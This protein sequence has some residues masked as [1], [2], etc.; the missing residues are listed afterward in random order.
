ML[1]GFL[2]RILFSRLF[3]AE[4]GKIKLLK[5]DYMLVHVPAMASIIY[6]FSK[7]SGGKKKLYDIGFESGGDVVE[8]FKKV[9][10][11]SRFVI[12]TMTELQEMM[13]WGKFEL[14][15]FDKKKNYMLIHWDSSI[16]HALLKSFGKQKEPMCSWPCG[17]F[18][19]AIG[20]LLDVKLRCE[21]TKCIARGDDHCELVLKGK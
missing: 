14:K 4:E 3:V 10:P 11:P 19:G 16:A 9:L 15:K 6:N 1:A 21:E 12:S 20:V 13:G 7:I 17:V 5:S 8:D 18:A 2:K